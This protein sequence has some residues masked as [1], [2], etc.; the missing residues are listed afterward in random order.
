[1]PRFNRRLL[2]EISTLFL[3]L[4]QLP[5]G[6]QRRIL[7]GS[8]ARSTSAL[9]NSSRLGA[10]STRWSL[11]R[12]R[13]WRRGWRWTQLVSRRWWWRGSNRA[14]RSNGRRWWGRRS[15]I[16]STFCW[17]TR[18]TTQHSERAWPSAQPTC[19]QSPLTLNPRSPLQRHPPT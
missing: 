17:T 5:W 15:H 14:L 9:D 3:L 7:R 19:T 1:M 2:I 8:S 10:A 11:G 6:Y 16:G 12:R 13:R 4:Q 18:I